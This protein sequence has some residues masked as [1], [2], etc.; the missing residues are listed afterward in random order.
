MLLGDMMERTDDRPL[1]ER[2]D[3]FNR[4]G[5]HVAP[6]VLTLG[7]VDRFVFGVLVPNALIGCPFVGDDTLCPVRNVVSD[8]LVKGAASPIVND[9]QPNVPIPFKSTDYQCLAFLAPAPYATPYA[10]HEGFVH[11]NGSQELS[12]VDLCHCRPDA[13]A[14]IPGGLVGDTEHP[15]QLIGGDALLGLAHGVGSKKPLPE[16]K[17]GVVHDGAGRD[18]EVVSALIATVLPS[19]LNGCYAS[20]EAPRADGTIRPSEG[21]EVHTTTIFGVEPFYQTDQVDFLSD[22]LS[23]S[24]VSYAT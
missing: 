4:V 1:Q 10:A 19:V 8:E 24:E 23:H 12:C 22:C 17:V 11:L 7:M 13:V 2:P 6:N 3:V 14:E 18:R 20:V 21:F 5:V 9:L 16:G 15:L